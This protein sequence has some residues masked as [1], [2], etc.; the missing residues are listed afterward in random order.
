MSMTQVFAEDNETITDP[1]NAAINS[2]TDDP[3][4]ASIF[5]DT[6]ATTLSEQAGASKQISATAGGD[7]MAQA[8][9]RLDPTELEGSNNWAKLAFDN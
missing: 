4:M 9:A 7:K 5:S 1:K 3:I 8:A 6:V 2:L